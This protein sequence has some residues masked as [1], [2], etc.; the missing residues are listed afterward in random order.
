MCLCSKQ[1]TSKST[2]Y[3][4]YTIV[5]HGS[6][7]RFFDVTIGFSVEDLSK[8]QYYTQWQLIGIIA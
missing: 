7:Y 3:N 8:K 5:K 2:S 4:V 1:N 6:N